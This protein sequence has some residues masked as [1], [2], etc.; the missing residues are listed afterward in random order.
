MHW[1]VGELFATPNLVSC[2]RTCRYQI[3]TSVSNVLLVSTSRISFQ[4][5]PQVLQISDLNICIKCMQV[6]VCS[7]TAASVW[8]FLAVA[9]CKR[10]YVPCIV[11][12]VHSCDVQECLYVPSQL[13]SSNVYYCKCL[14][15]PLQLHYK[16]LDVP[17]SIKTFLLIPFRHCATHSSRNPFTTTCI[18]TLE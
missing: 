14:Y 5:P 7:F 4:Y 1:L 9:M 2:L 8:M 13:Q 15:V 10:L 3:W 16:C 11:L 6:F 17:R 18:S 12:D